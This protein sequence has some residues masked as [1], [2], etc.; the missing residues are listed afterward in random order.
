M[1]RFCLL[2][3]AIAVVLATTAFGDTVTFSGSS[4]G[5][6]GLVGLG[7]ALVFV[8]GPLDMVKGLSVCPA[9]CAINGGSVVFISGAILGPPVV[10]NPTTTRTDFDSGGFLLL[11]GAVSGG[12]TGIL[13]LAQFAAG[14]MLIQDTTT[15]VGAYSAPLTNINIDSFFGTPISGNNNDTLTIALT[16]GGILLVTGTQTTI[17]TQGGPTT[18]PEPATLTLLGAGLLGLSQIIVRRW[19]DNNM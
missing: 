5:G 2:A 11:T 14:G 1:K 13:L 9:G 18:T 10:V 4:P 17:D 16:P 8:G 7:S 6:T 3:F 12:P 15:G 19:R